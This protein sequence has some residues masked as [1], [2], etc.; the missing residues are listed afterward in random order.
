MAK[1][2]TIFLNLIKSLS[3][4]KKSDIIAGIGCPDEIFKM[5]HQDLKK[6]SSL[7]DHDIKAIIEARSSGVLDTELSDIQRKNIAVIDIFDEQYPKLLKE[8]SHPPLVL[9]IRGNTDVLNQ[10]CLAVV[11]S[12]KA[13]SYGIAMADEFSAQ[14]ASLGLVIVSGLARGID[15][16]AHRAALR[17]GVT[18]AVMGSGLNNVYPRENRELADK[19]SQGGAVISEYP[20]N[21]P[22]LKENF[23]RRNRI[24]SG[25]SKGV[26]VIE[27]ALRSGALITARRGCE[28]NRDI[29]AL[30]GKVDSAL[31]KGTH[32]LIKE[33]AKLVESV[34][35]IIEELPFE[36]IGAEEKAANNC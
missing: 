10:R 13:T 25:L 19:I 26:L 11:G 32:A 20:M 29:F 18:I 24:I 33:G 1:T 27:A 30:P 23:P 28:Q 17:E 9:Y 6:I 7:N 35:D 5:G 16:A 14:L 34:E 31:S 3:P 36:F 2:G 4:Q 22:P 8:I 21:E 15:S 12:R